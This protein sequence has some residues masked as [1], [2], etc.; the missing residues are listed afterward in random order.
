MHSGGSHI[1]FADG[2]VKL[3]KANTLMN[4]KTN[5]FLADT[6]FNNDKAHHWDAETGQWYNWVYTGSEL[7][8]PNNLS[9][10]HI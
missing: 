9:L 2:H 8:D 1:L 5:K 3:V 7:N 10:I 6:D 4:P